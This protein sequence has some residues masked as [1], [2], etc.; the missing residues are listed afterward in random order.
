MS[1]KRIRE[2]EEE[3]AE[4]KQDLKAVTARCDEYATFLRDLPLYCLVVGPDKNVKRASD[5]LLQFLGVTREDVV[6]RQ[7]GDVFKCLGHL[8]LNAGRG[9]G[10]PC[11][12]CKCFDIIE[13]TFATGKSCKQI[14]VSVDSS[15]SSLTGAVFLISSTRV[16]IKGVAHVVLYLDDITEQKKAEQALIE[17]TE[18][19]RT[20]FEYS[21]L[22]IHVIDLEGHILEVNRRWTD[23]LGYT[24]DEVIGR[25]AEEFLQKGSRDRLV[26]HLCPVFQE[27]GEVY[28][29]PLTFE[30]RIGHVVETRYTAMLGQWEGSNVPYVICACEN[31]SHQAAMQRALDE[32]NEKY[33]HLFEYTPI[34]IFHCDV[35]G[36][37]VDVNDYLCSTFQV[38]REDV[39][40]ENAYL[41][42]HDEALRK[43]LQDALRTGY[44]HF[45]GEY[46]SRFSG[47]K[48]ILDVMTQRLQDSHGETIGL[49]GVIE[50]VTYAQNNADLIRLQRD[51]GV[52]LSMTD[53][54]PQT[55]TI[56]LGAVVK[57]AREECGSIYIRDV[58][59]HAFYCLDQY[60]L[61]AQVLEQTD[62]FIA[63]AINER[64]LAGN[65]TVVL[66]ANEL[67]KP[68]DGLCSVTLIPVNHEEQCIAVFAVYSRHQT[69]LPE[70]TLYALEVI[71]GQAAV[72]LVKARMHQE[73]VQNEKNL[74][75]LFTS[76]EEFLFVL[77]GAGTVVVHNPVVEQRLGYSSEELGRMN[78]LDLHPPDRRP[79]A[80]QVVARM[81]EGQEEY[82][83]IPIMKK[84]G[85]LIPV[86]TKVTHG[87]WNDKEVIFGIS[88]DVSERLEAEKAR[89]L[90]EER[91]LLALQEK[92]ALLREIHHRVKNNM[93]V[94]ISLLG[95]QA[96]KFNDPKVLSV[97]S[98]A[99]GRV[100]SMSLVHEILYTSDKLSVIGVEK[101]LG[102]LTKQLCQIFS[103]DSFQVE[104]V[105]EA[106]GVYWGIDHAIPCG[107][108]MTELITNAFK[109]A[110]PH[111]RGGT[112][113]IIASHPEEGKT[114]F[115][116]A[117]D[118]VGLPAD[119][120]SSCGKT[121]GLRLVKGLVEDQLE[122]TLSIDSNEGTRFVIE[123]TSKPEAG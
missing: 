118:G 96:A 107:L 64:L 10:Q 14:E 123:F 61:S 119:Y 120:E 92:E 8:E 5:N 19:F 105:V 31:V 69:Q 36:D 50:D 71:A 16:D 114:R 1:E 37:I 45:R 74:Q 57:A 26:N 54:L 22:M 49:I 95:L 58:Q 79:E 29:E 121:L 35:D 106:E 27:R 73:L 86:E 80:Q 15:L 115:V 34:C 6:G 103:E 17:T 60:G 42:I 2:L 67:G 113:R 20:L 89:K 11:R 108:V 56:A 62:P 43:S 38:S 70:F 66:S 3:L 24:R 46:L 63:S 81:L 18:R 33:K 98:E 82:C 53:E 23:T 12:R 93:Q 39:V 52:Q 72:A 102:R 94:V 40:G 116:I 90:S 84:D 122:G 109:Y 83:H 91:I 78:V 32:S 77:D 104:L 112:V 68:V 44:G 30:T 28:N 51:I 111:G 101:Y 47:K 25:K 99:E 65:K 97:F 85:S 117:D 110:F 59:T 4:A 55:A 13:E 9:K 48:L 76:L 7:V 41:L 88:R 87:I 21:P 75:T 100:L